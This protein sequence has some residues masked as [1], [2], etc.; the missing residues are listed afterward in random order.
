[1]DH[2][3]PL[4][5]I[6]AYAKQDIGA[7]DRVEAKARKERD[8]ATR[9]MRTKLASSKTKLRAFDL[10][11]TEGRNYVRMMEDHNNLME[12]NTGGRLREAMH[13]VGVRCVDDGLLDRPEQALHLS[14]DELERLASD[15]NR[16]KARELVRERE[17]EYRQQSRLKPPMKLGLG[18]LPPPPD[19]AKTWEIPADSGRDGAK[20]KGVSGS[21]GRASGRARVVPHTDEMPD[22]QEGDILVAPNAGPDWTPVFP[23]I[24]G[25]VLD[26][27]AVFQHAALV[28]REY[29]IP[30]VI[31]T[32]E[33]TTT[34]DDGSEI[35][36]D[37]DEGVVHLP[38]SGPVAAIEEVQDFPISWDDPADEQYGWVLASIGQRDVHPTTH[39]E[40]DALEFYTAGSKVCLEKT[41][42]PMARLNI[43]HYQNGYR[44]VRTPEIDEDEVD[45][46]LAKLRA[47]SE[48]IVNKGGSWWEV[49]IKPDVE[50]VLAGLEGVRPGRASLRELVDHLERAFKRLRPRARR[51][52]LEAG[53]LPR[54]PDGLGAPVQRGDG[55]AAHRSR[56]DRAGR[57]KQDDAD[58]ALAE[59][60]CPRR[61]ERRAATQDLRRPGL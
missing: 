26:Q 18:D 51:P 5:L 57:R 16:L 44:Y 19:M 53:R 39:L 24:A 56:H 40:R 46:K 42:S 50:R 59:G 17:R 43:H 4:R 20:L 23:L 34:I 13:A 11:V 22:V 15:R 36:V 29:K 6:A 9:R 48:R 27:G 35:T 45:R 31:M 52:A 47:R 8:E 25:L 3:R 10:A 58:G 61:A 32:K 37:G 33:A 60:P 30:A 12:Q 28:A 54:R 49:D 14:L 55:L 38:Q 1:M 7:M 2:A 41:G 21:R